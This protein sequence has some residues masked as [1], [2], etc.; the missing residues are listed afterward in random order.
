MPKLTKTYLLA[1]IAIVF[2]ALTLCFTRKSI[3]ADGLPSN[4]VGKQAQLIFPTSGYVIQHDYLS[5]N[6]LRWTV[7]ESPQPIERSQAEQ[8]IVAQPI[9]SHL[10]MLNWVEYDGTSVSEVID[11]EKGK[12]W[13]YWTLANS[14]DGATN[15]RTGFFETGNFK[16]IGH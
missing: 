13:A 10:I 6:S 14:T 4:L 5:N 9:D 2:L 3:A 11:T 12:I 8:T 16:F 15:G 7:I 1:G